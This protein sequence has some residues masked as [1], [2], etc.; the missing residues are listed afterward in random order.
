[1]R[2]GVKHR[3]WADEIPFRILVISFGEWKAEDQYRFD[4][5]YGRTGQPLTL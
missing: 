3:F 2:P 1:M 4:D 5:D